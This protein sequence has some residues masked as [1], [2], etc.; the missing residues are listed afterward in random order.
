MRATIVDPVALK[1]ISPAALRGYAEFEGWQRVKSYGELSEIYNRQI[2]ERS[3]EI[4][5][6]VT[7]RIG[8]YPSVV[9]QL[10]SIFAKENNIGELEIFRDLTHADRDVI[11]FRSSYADDDGS[12]AIESGVE[13]VTE[14]RNVLA[15]AACSAN[16][17]QE[18]YHVGKIQI[19]ADYMRR[20]RLGQTEAGSFTV[21]LLAP[22][23]PLIQRAKGVLWP[24]LSLEPYDRQVTRVLATGLQ[25]TSE[26]LADLNRGRDISAFEQAVADGVSANLCEAIAAIAERGDGANISITWARTRPAPLERTEVRFARRDAESLRE[27]ARYFRL[28]EPRNDVVIL[29]N[30]TRLQRSGRQTSGR[31][32]F[33]TFIDGRPRSVTVELPREEYE[34]AVDAHKRRKP[35]I[36]TGDLVRDGQRWHLRNPRNL[37]VPT[38]EA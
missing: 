12:I 4:V 8:D 33:V 9:S 29:G 11:R 26:A 18:A 17:P 13:L 30:T 37:I 5:L 16:E 19:A 35:I 7:D 2:G 32:T 1:A 14:A 24:E 25:A 28:R 36:I 15:S 6:P 23:P 10:I 21:T 38:P 20:V 27:V 3:V 22:V 34:K 31:V